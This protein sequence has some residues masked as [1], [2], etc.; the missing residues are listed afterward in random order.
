MRVV[1]VKTGLLTLRFHAQ[2]L[3]ANA[4]VHTHDS[5]KAISGVRI[6]GVELLDNPSRRGN[7]AHLAIARARRAPAS[8]GFDVG[9]GGELPDIGRLTA[10]HLK[11]AGW[12]AKLHH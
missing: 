3:A 10:V 5:A 12:R 11:C 6:L 4:A 1:I 2:A 9:H 8:V 7:D